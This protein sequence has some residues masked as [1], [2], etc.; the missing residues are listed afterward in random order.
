MVIADSKSEKQEI[1][2]APRYSGEISKQD[3]AHI[4]QCER[5]FEKNREELERRYWGRYIALYEG[6]ILLD[7]ECLEKMLEE[8][9]KMRGEGKLKHL[10]F[11]MRVYSSKAVATC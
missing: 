8:L 4:E 10:P 7:S 6:S 9:G 2:S 3:L 5:C 11:V 1:E